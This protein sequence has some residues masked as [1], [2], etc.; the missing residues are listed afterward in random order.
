MKIFKIKPDYVIEL[1]SS[2]VKKLTKTDKKIIRTYTKSFVDNSGKIDLKKFSEIVIP[3]IKELMEPGKEVVCIATALYRSIKNSKDVVD[4]VRETT[5]LEVNIISGDKEAELIGKAVMKEYPGRKLLVVDTGSMSTE[6][7]I[8]PGGYHHSYK[9]NHPMVL[10]KEIVLDLK[11]SRD[12][13]IVV[14]GETIY[15]MGKVIYNPRTELSWH[16]QLQTIINQIGVHPVVGTMATPGSG[17][18]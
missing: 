10:D 18:L 11:K 14:T 3:A 2:A 17:L 16:K 15:K 8:F 4:L 9:N 5:G 13:L 12:L 7:C 1:S 6:I